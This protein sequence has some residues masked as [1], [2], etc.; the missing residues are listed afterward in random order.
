MAH[1]GAVAASQFDGVWV[2]T[3]SGCTGESEIELTVRDGA[4][5]WRGNVGNVLSIQGKVD[6]TGSIG[7]LLK[8]G[9]SGRSWGELLLEGQIEGDRWRSSSRCL[10]GPWR[11]DESRSLN[12]DL[13]PQR[14]RDTQAATPPTTGTRR[15]TVTEVQRLLARLGYDPGPAD[16][17]A[18]PR[19]RR[20]IRDFQRDQSIR[21]DG[22]PGTDLLDRLRGRVAEVES[23]SPSAQTPR[24]SD[25]GLEDLSDLDN[26]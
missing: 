22:V 11:F 25:A 15:A 6:S 20:A 26:F 18:G 12:L 8:G 24:K 2:G 4:F 23:T 16:G 7:A 13:R 21:V 9:K 14:V 17:A 3:L 19:T 10:V 5:D 1:S